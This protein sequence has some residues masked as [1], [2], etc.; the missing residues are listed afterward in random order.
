MSTGSRAGTPEHLVVEPRPVRG[1]G[2]GHAGEPTR[3]PARTA[4][5]PRRRAAGWRRARRR[6]ARPR[7][8]GRSGARGATGAPTSTRTRRTSGGAITATGSTGAPVAIAAARNGS[9]AAPTRLD[10]R[11]SHQTAGSWPSR[12][13]PA[14]SSGRASTPP[15]RRSAGPIGATSAMPVK[16][17]S[18]PVA[19]PIDAATSSGVAA[20][21]PAVGHQ[22]RGPRRRHVVRAADRDGPPQRGQRPGQP[23]QLGIHPPGVDLVG[24]DGVTP[25]HGEGA[26][27]ATSDGRRWITVAHS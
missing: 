6:P 8:A 17:T 26:H 27:A 13:R 14:T 16:R 21:Q 1:P 5:S 24:T 22:E 2:E 23:D 7:P 18:R 9:G 11:A 15:T 12:S 3:G 10:E 25:Q 19:R 20:Q 4:G